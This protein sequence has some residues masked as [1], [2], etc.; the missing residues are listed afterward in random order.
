MPIGR[1]VT[2]IERWGHYHWVCGLVDMT[3]TLNP[4]CQSPARSAGND[5]IKQTQR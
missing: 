1:R 3:T 4:N 2:I 5:S